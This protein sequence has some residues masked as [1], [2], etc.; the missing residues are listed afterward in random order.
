MPVLTEEQR[1]ES[2][3]D[4]PRLRE[5]RDLE[6]RRYAAEHGLQYDEATRI[7]TGREQAAEVLPDKLSQA[8]QRTARLAR[9]LEQAEAAEAAVG[10]TAREWNS[11]LTRWEQQS[12]L[13]VQ[14]EDRASLYESISTEQAELDV[15]RQALGDQTREAALFSQLLQAERRAK[16]YRRCAGV[17]REELVALE[18]EL[19]SF[20]RKHGIETKCL[21]ATLQ[22]KL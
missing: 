16:A 11:L 21:P 15:V 6:I 12:A 7:L 10:R 22:G 8:Q 19:I 1:I 20:A 5:E 4:A 14:A 17:L 3:M 13:V 9:E 18:A 2:A